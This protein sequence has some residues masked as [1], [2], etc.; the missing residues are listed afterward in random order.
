MTTK[1]TILLLALFAHNT[2]HACE[3]AEI[4]LD[5]QT[6]DRLVE[7]KL[8]HAEMVFMGKIAEINSKDENTDLITF[9]VIEIFKGKQTNKITME[10]F[11]CLNYPYRPGRK[12]FVSFLKPSNSHFGSEPVTF[13]AQHGTAEIKLLTLM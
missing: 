3:C 4:P 13:V 1:V 6:T 9:E 11:I 7:Y 8:D 5:L 2:I 12:Y 10:Q